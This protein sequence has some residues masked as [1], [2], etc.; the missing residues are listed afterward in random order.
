[1][2]VPERRREI[3]KPP[4]VGEHSVGMCGRGSHSCLS[5]LGWCLTSQGGAWVM[6]P[7]DIIAW[8]I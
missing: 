7:L 3:S 6:R 1:M 2:G 5:L 4:H 8:C